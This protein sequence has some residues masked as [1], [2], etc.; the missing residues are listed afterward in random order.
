[1]SLPSS[2]RLPFNWDREG[3]SLSLLRLAFSTNLSRLILDISS[4]FV[5]KSNG[6][7]PSQ[8]GLATPVVVILP[9][10]KRIRSIHP[11]FL[12]LQRGWCSGAPFVL[13]PEPT[14]RWSR[15]RQPVGLTGL[16]FERIGV[17]S[18]ATRS[19]SKLLRKSVRDHKRFLAQLTHSRL[20]CRL[21]R[22]EM[23]MTPPM[24]TTS[25]DERHMRSCS[26]KRFGASGTLPCA[27]HGRGGVAGRSTPCLHCASWK[28][29]RFWPKLSCKLFSPLFRPRCHGRR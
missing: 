24:V 17:F 21:A 25:R 12:V 14:L 16:S 5:L 8:Q 27:A 3:N 22:L 28:P 6:K 18:P 13:H 4:S 10:P 9:R 15:D 11:Y 20:R 23:T 1:V 26:P 7:A 19:E 2:T 29:L